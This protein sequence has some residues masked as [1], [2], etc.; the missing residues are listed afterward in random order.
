MDLLGVQKERMSEFVRQFPRY[1]SGRIECDD[2]ELGIDRAALRERF[3]FY[4]NA[5]HV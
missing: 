1:K 2:S 5:A 4:Y 3:G